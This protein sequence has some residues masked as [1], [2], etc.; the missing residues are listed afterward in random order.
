VL[1]EDAKLYLGRSS[2]FSILPSGGTAQSTTLFLHLALLKDILESYSSST[3]RTS[4]Y[5]RWSRTLAGDPQL[6]TIS[7]H[8]S[9]VCSDSPV[10]HKSF[11][12]VEKHC[13]FLGGGE[14]R[15][16]CGERLQSNSV[17]LRFP[18]VHDYPSSWCKKLRWFG[19]PWRSGLCPWPGHGTKL[20]STV[21]GYAGLQEHPMSPPISSSPHFS[22]SSK[23]HVMFPLGKPA[24]SQRA[25]GCL[26]SW[27]CTGWSKAS[28]PPMP[29]IASRFLFLAHYQSSIK[30][31]TFTETA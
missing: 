25:A 18:R 27:L 1:L 20:R 26:A 15:L 31:Q 7:T 29:S 16:L 13:Q 12:P 21:S 5:T 9:P 17:H 30:A 22:E 23:R 6:F 11:D 3:P 8:T 19:C 28:P 4:K 10:K 2:R 14:S 24:S